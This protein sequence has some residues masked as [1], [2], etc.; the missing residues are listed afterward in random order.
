M[1]EYVCKLCPSLLSRML[2]A[3][4][5]ML[6]NEVLLCPLH[7]AAAWQQSEPSVSSIPLLAV[8]NRCATSMRGRDLAT[9]LCCL[10]A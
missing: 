7:L 10:F 3:C 8:L 2:S 6:S 1:A 9:R 5:L 4:N